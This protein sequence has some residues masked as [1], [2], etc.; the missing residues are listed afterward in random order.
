M[1]GYDGLNVNPHNILLTVVYRIGVVGLLI[2][3][4]LFY[5][6]VRKKYVSSVGLTFITVSL[7]GVV[8][9]SINQIIFWILIYLEHMYET[10]N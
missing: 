3:T 10:K 7:F 4:Y 1:K 5:K 6:I 8:F 9:E 2:F